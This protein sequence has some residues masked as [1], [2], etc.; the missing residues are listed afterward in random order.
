MSEKIRMVGSLQDQ[1]VRLETASSDAQKHLTA[2]SNKLVKEQ[3]RAQDAEELAES[4]KSKII[5]YL[6]LTL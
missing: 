3:T 6:F 4:L 2:L 5:S 1:M